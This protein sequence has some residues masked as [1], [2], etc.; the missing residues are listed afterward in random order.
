MELWIW[1]DFSVNLYVFLVLSPVPFHCDTHIM[2]VNTQEGSTCG[3]RRDVRA[4][5]TQ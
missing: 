2:V 1:K 3:G 4:G 5:K